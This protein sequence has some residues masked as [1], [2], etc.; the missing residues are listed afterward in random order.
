MRLTVGLSRIKP[1]I[2]KRKL[3]KLHYSLE[4]PRAKRYYIHEMTPILDKLL[5]DT[6]DSR[7]RKP[8]TKYLI[9]SNVSVIEDFLSN[10][11]RRIIDENDL[12]ISELITDEIK[13]ILQEKQFQKL[14]KGEVIAASYGYANLK[15]IDYVFSKLLK[16]PFIEY[17]LRISREDPARDIKGA[18]LLHKNWEK[19]EEMFDARNKIVH[20]MADV[21]LSN[22][23]IISLCDNTLS[24]MDIASALREPSYCKELVDKYGYSK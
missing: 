3:A 16:F 10:L 17:I 12:D 6:F 13:T 21:Q 4:W 5:D 24:F 20:A 9:I 2:D 19:F 15:H 22:R 11:I 8:L 1:R 18:I 7:L 23:A 14:T